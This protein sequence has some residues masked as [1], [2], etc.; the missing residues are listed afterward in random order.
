MKKAML[1]VVACALLSFIQIDRSHAAAV[2]M[3]LFIDG[4]P[5]E[6][7]QP[8]FANWIRVE[9]AAWSHGSGSSVGGG[10]ASASKGGYS[11]SRA[12][13]E[14]LAVTKFVDFSSP[15]LALAV[16]DG[17]H[18]KTAILVF[19]KAAGVFWKITL[20]D[21]IVKVYKAGHS[22]G[23]PFPTEQVTLG[24]ARIEWNYS[25]QMPDGKLSQPIRSGW[26][27]SKNTPF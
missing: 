24:F 21:V 27:L 3:F 10:G 5:G 8:P 18:F 17:R 25:R 7:T 13:F 4:V 12:V 14:A 26:D 16:A 20:T 6:V 15:M 2:D 19:Q 22:G 9:S 23:A 1:M 11:A